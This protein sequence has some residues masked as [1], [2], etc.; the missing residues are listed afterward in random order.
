M[1][2][3]EQIAFDFLKRDFGE[4]QIVFEPNGRDTFPDFYMGGIGIEVA[5]IHSP[6]RRGVIN[7]PGTLDKA[8]KKAIENVNK[9]ICSHC[10]AAN[11][12]SYY[13][14]VDLVTNEYSPSRVRKIV[15]NI[16]WCAY[17]KTYVDV[18]VIPLEIRLIRVESK[19]QGFYL[20]G[21]TNLSNVGA[22]VAE[23]YKQA[24]CS[25][26]QK[27]TNILEK[28]L[29]GGEVNP[30]LSTYMLILVDSLYPGMNVEDELRSELVRFSS[31]KF[32]KII[33]VDP[34]NGCLLASV[35]LEA[36]WPG[37]GV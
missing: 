21:G 29:S 13:V 35:P 7:Y 19:G 18:D 34:K 17:E 11:M 2:P 4:E 31:G 3:S 24:L 15:E 25:A 8:V 9:K 32:Q 37:C 5:E 28:Y 23:E 30:A 36:K 12:H 14:A 16:L 26:I 1:N 27:K 6:D 10:T 20:F 33:V 22:M